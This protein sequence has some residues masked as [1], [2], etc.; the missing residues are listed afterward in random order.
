MKHF[1]KIKNSKWVPN[2]TKKM[3][4]ENDDGKLFLG[5]PINYVNSWNL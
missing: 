2:S 5:P 4:H 3:I 1:L